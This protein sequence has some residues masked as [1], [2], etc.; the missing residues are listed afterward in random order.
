MG[1]VRLSQPRCSLSC[2]RR[3]GRCRPAP[4][5][6]TGRT[7]RWSGTRPRERSRA[8]L[9]VAHGSP[10]QT[11][12]RRGKRGAPPRAR[13]HPSGSVASLSG[14][15]GV[16]AR[17][18]AHLSL[19][20]LG[21]LRPRRRGA[22]GSRPNSTAADLKNDLFRVFLVL[23]R[24]GVHN[25]EVKKDRTRYDL[26]SHA[27]VHGLGVAL[28]LDRPHTRLGERRR[29]DE[30]GRFQEPRNSTIRACFWP[31]RKPPRL[32]AR[33]LERNLLIGVVGEGRTSGKQRKD[34]SRKNSQFRLRLRLSGFTC[35]RAIALGSR[36]E[37][38][39]WRDRHAK[40]D[41]SRPAPTSSGRSVRTE[42]LQS[43]STV[44]PT[45]PGHRGPNTEFLTLPGPPRRSCTRPPS[46][47]T[48][49]P[50]HG[51]APHNPSA[52]HLR[53]GLIRF[54][55]LAPV[56]ACASPAHCHQVWRAAGPGSVPRWR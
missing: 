36:K 22:R 46:R 56:R 27:A 28:T 38:T 42:L 24:D 45:R 18:P 23:V 37:D 30:W 34:G 47:R 54:V 43:P 31:C 33:S 44:G 40:G 7:G 4:S 8:R 32:A 5:R 55:C 20:R 50:P 13:F 15:T 16:T 12:H 48:P 6:S 41:G 19:N 25:P 26:A 17:R 11:R 1:R 14:E 52:R 9:R 49:S 39:A 51:T 10:H 29:C 21:G 3:A 53:M 35:L 2:V